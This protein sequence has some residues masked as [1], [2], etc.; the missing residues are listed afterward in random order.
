MTAVGL[1]IGRF[2]PFHLG[3]LEVVKLIL[4]KVDELIIVVGS[5]QYSHT[6]S[7]PFTV[8][9]RIRMIRESLKED[10][11]NLD[12]VQITPITDVNVHGIWV[13]HISLYVGKIDTVFS[14][15]PLTSQLFNEAGFKVDSIPFFKREI[16]SA[17]EIRNRIL[18]DHNWREL[19]PKSV[20]NIIDSIKGV[21]RMMILLH[22]DNPTI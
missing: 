18:T 1:Y 6:K 2:Q 14:N 7:N 10:K 5:A 11:I 20:S 8:G 21:E 3:H 19:V 15:D 4:R 16:Y 12:R 9:E 13:H 22:T 17:T